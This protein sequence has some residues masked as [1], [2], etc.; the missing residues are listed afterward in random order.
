MFKFKWP[1]LNPPFDE[2]SLRL[3]LIN[4]SAQ[5]A[6]QR[7]LWGIPKSQT[8]LR[9]QVRAEDLQREHRAAGSR[10]INRGVQDMI[11]LRKGVGMCQAWG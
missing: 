7:L 9:T 4:L 10:R 8:H 1:R 6:R 2:A 3:L 11:P 5:I